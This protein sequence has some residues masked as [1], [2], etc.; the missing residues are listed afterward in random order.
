MA[1]VAFRVDASI[2]IGTGHLV[3]C[4]TLATALSARHFDVIFIMR[5]TVVGLEDLVRAKGFRLEILPPG[6]TDGLPDAA[7]TPHA[8]W[9]PVSWREDARQ[10][11]D[12][13]AHLGAM[14]WL[15]VDH[16]AL[17]AE[18][19]NV[20]RPLCKHILAID[21]L[22]DRRHD[23]DVLVD[24]NLVVGMERR[25]DGLVP[26]SCQRLVGPPYALLRSEFAELRHR[27]RRRDES[28]SRVFVFMGGTDATNETGKVLEA[29]GQT[30]ASTLAI[31]VVVGAANPHIDSI[32]RQL[33]GLSHA[34][35]HTQVSDM[36]EL[37]AAA[38]LSVGAGGGAT[39][40]R[41]CLGLPTIALSIANNQT[42]NLEALAQH[43]CVLYLGAATT[44]DT[45]AL[46]VALTSIMR[47]PDLV[48][49]MAER[50]AAIT[51]GLGCDRVVSALSGSAGMVSARQV[52]A[53]DGND[54][55]D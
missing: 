5:G 29:L 30:P 41:C 2:E 4:L 43:G 44:V 12:M 1:R 27:A 33:R 51:D 7:D 54:Q 16:Y 49:T 23:C 34:R 40:E 3:R 52:T 46:V 39:W 22:A 20:Q 50:S 18:W 36:A 8:H 13:L 53:E 55:F 38:D 48:M 31:D 26:V 35:L 17:G 24:Q 42:A 45:N 6:A 25:Y 11:R 32:Q 19:E 14:D 10:T 47:S 9:L 15:I 37:M 28:I 21:D